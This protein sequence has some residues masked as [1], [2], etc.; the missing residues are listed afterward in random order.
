MVTARR[1]LTDS[2]GE[3]ITFTGRV[4]SKSL[5]SQKEG[6]LVDDDTKPGDIAQPL[7]V[8]ENENAE[9]EEKSKENQEENNEDQD[10]DMSICKPPTGDHAATQFGGIAVAQSAPGTIHIL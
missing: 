2:S 1:R 6:F 3:E 9:D 4:V 5:Q 8:V 7:V 10:I